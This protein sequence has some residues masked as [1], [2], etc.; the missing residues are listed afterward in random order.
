[1]ATQR[2][3]HAGDGPAKGPLRFP[4]PSLYRPSL[5]CALGESKTERLRYGSDCLRTNAKLDRCRFAVLDEIF[6]TG[7]LGVRERCSWS[8][9]TLAVGCRRTADPTTG[10]SLIQINY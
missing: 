6:V 2:S 7:C 4:R 9:S 8:S 3:P 10:R 1:M 5:A